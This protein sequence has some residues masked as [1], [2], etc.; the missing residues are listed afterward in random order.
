MRD[1]TIESEKDEYKQIL[2]KLLK[3]REDIYRKD[4]RKTMIKIVDRYE[5]YLECY[6]CTG[7]Y[8]YKVYMNIISS[9]LEL[10]INLEE[11]MET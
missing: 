9:Q 1:S 11:V 5:F 8:K 2:R 3:D 6:M 7:N 4:I 10:F